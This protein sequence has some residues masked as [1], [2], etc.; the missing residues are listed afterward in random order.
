MELA[1]E[2]TAKAGASAH[3]AFHRR[4]TVHRGVAWRRARRYLARRGSSERQESGMRCA[5][6]AT[7]PSMTQAVA[8]SVAWFDLIVVVN[9][10]FRLALWAHALAAN[11]HAWWRRNPDSRE[12]AGRK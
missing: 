10:A 9:D 7:G 8:D 2:R 5:I 6:L 3:C 4:R 11:D 1:R 12:F